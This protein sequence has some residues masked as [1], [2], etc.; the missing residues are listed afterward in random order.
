MTSLE[1]VI[2]TLRSQESELRAM[3][4]SLAAVFGSIARGAASDGSD[5]DVLVD[6]DPTRRLSL[7]EFIAIKHYL[8]DTFGRSVDLVSRRGLSAT[9]LPTI[10]RDMVRVF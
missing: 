3:G 1:D 6:L 10:E 8:D 5:I 4:V 7:F 9:M 2:T